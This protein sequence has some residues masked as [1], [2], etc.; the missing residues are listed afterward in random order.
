MDDNIDKYTKDLV[1]E[2]SLKARQALGEVFAN[3]RELN[4]ANSG[5]AAAVMNSVFLDISCSQIA[6]LCRVGQP[7]DCHEEFLKAQVEHFETAL[8][9][10]FNALIEHYG[11]DQH[12]NNIHDLIKE[13]LSREDG[14]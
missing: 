3:S 7:E 10:Y 2:L 9:A 8:F 13:K 14:E 6:H 1:E 12:K 4:L 5:I 11:D